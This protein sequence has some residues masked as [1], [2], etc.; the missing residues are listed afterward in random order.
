MKRIITS[1]LA[2]TTL[3][4]AVSTSAQTIHLSDLNIVEKV[5]VTVQTVQSPHYNTSQ[6]VNID[7]TDAISKLGLQGLSMSRQKFYVAQ[8]DALSEGQKDELTDAFNDKKGEGWWMT[9]TFDENTGSETG[10][11]VADTTSTIKMYLRNL[12]LDNKQLTLHVGQVAGMLEPNKTYTSSIYYINGNNAIEIA[13]SQVVS[14]Q[15]E[16]RLSDMEKKGEQ[17][18]QISMPYNGSY[19]KRDIV[20]PD[21]MLD[22]LMGFSDEVEQELDTVWDENPVPV[23]YALSKENLLSD[24]ATANNGGY[25]IDNHGYIC[26]WGTDSCTLFFEPND[27]L[28]VQLLHVGMYPNYQLQNNTFQASV[29]IVGKDNA[30]MQVNLTFEVTPQPT[31]LECE[32]VET[33]DLAMEIIPDLTVPHTPNVNL[34]QDSYMHHAINLRIDHLI[35]VLEGDILDFRVENTLMQNDGTITQNY[36]GA[37]SNYI[38]EGA[39]YLMMNTFGLF[40]N[41]ELLHI[42]ASL[43]P[44]PMMTKAYGIGYENGYLSFWYQPGD[45]AIGD[46]YQNHFYLVNF[47]AGKKIQLNVN[48]IFVEQRS[49]SIDIVKEIDLNLP[50]HNSATNDFAS[51]N[52]DLSAVIDSLQ[53]GTTEMITW[54]AYNQLAQLVHPAS[55]DDIYGFSLADNGKIADSEETAIFSVGYNDGTFHSMVQKPSENAIYSTAI[56]AT[57]NGKGVR[58]NINL[59]DHMPEDVNGDGT[60]DTQDVLKIYDYMR[61]TNSSETPSLEDV[62]GDGTVDTQDVLKIYEYIKTN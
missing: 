52:Y 2:A 39:G 47:D 1:V 18:V 62:N 59:V 54:K 44:Y 31:L 25:W 24:N 61:Q 43:S 5:E 20:I 48:V 60:I 45:A 57:Y 33:L 49:P 53:C 22:R 7:L 21:T 38:T 16:L 37:Q 4:F 8:F 17:E 41:E 14:A 27:T 15:P 13:I 46:Y 58:F 23:L 56:V 55:Y 10:I 6:E 32:T 40:Q 42:A 26:D 30:Y 50:T 28:G 34:V 3:I 36:I 9:E 29:Y 35:E 51:T 12:S 11:C 19:R